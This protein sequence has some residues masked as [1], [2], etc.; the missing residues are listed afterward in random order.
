[1]IKVEAIWFIVA[2]QTCVTHFCCTLKT[3]SLRAPHV[4]SITKLESSSDS[5][6]ATTDSPP[7]SFIDC[8]KQAVA[9]TDRAIFD[10]YKL[11]EV[12]FPPLPLEYLEDS[13][14]SAKEI[15]NANTKW[16]VEFAL[17]F[18]NRKRISV[19]YPDQP[20][21]DDALTY[22]ANAGYPSQLPNITMATTRTDSIKN[23][24]SVDELISSI[25]GAV[26]GGKVERIA[27]TDMYVAIISTTQEL[28]DLEKLHELDPAATI[29]FF[30]LRLDVLVS[31]HLIFIFC[32]F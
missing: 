4:H 21:L 19:I 23:A 15:S 27:D 17:R 32:M 8:V 28:Q 6:I 24:G 1:M 16:A 2:L 12:D 30:N 3:S 31:K 14:S 25:F 26:M 22:L 9:S 18:S 20:E 5:L 11:I 13:S 29:V 10:G 7:N